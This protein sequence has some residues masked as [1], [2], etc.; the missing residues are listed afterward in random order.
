MSLKLGFACKKTADPK[1]IVD[2]NLKK[3]H[4]KAGYCHEKPLIFY[5]SGVDT[6]LKF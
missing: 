5:L 2:L 3:N 1:G 6:F 4:F